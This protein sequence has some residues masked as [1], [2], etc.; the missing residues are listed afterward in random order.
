MSFPKPD[1][2][3]VTTLRPDSR[4]ES[5]LMRHSQS[6]RLLYMCDSLRSLH[7]DIAAEN[8]GLAGAQIF[9]RCLQIWQGVAH[10]DESLSLR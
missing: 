7:A 4:P 5:A 9:E 3:P 2:S 10:I 8:D 6:F 1:L